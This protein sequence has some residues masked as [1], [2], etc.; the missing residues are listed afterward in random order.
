MLFSLFRNKFFPNNCQLVLC[1]CFQSFKLMI[2][3]FSLNDL[4]YEAIVNI[5]QFRSY[6]S[7]MLHFQSH[8]YGGNLH[9]KLNIGNIC[10][11]SNF[12]LSF[13]RRCTRTR[14]MWKHI[15]NWWYSW[16][17]LNCLTM[18]TLIVWKHIMIKRVYK[19]KLKHVISYWSMM[20][21]EQPHL[22]KAQDDEHKKVTVII[23]WRA[24]T[25]TTNN[26]PLSKTE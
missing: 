14:R 5:I 22:R 6:N 4:K 3:I 24:I 8:S 17:G 2:L 15:C 20:S 7:Y 21:V 19:H 18:N 11:Y 12:W 26:K 16:W 25:S 13:Y 23:S 10:C 9:D 1:H